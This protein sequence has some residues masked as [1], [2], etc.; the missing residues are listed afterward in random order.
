MS[1]SPTV[2]LNT[3]SPARVR[4]GGEIA[5]PLKLH[6]LAGHGLRQRGLNE[7]LGQKL[8]RVRVQVGQRIAIG[9]G[10]GA[11]EQVRI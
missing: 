5:A 8:Q 4:I 2:R 9:A 6:R 7:S 11:V 1:R 3:G 10:I